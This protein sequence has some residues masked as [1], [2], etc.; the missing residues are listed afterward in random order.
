MEQMLVSVVAA[1]RFRYEHEEWWSGE[2]RP[3][4]PII[5]QHQD[6]DQDRRRDGSCVSQPS[7][8][9]KAIS[10]ALAAP[11]AVLAPSCP[12]RSSR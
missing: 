12:D 2:D 6:R 10:R 11:G 9:R 8:R 3:G 7:A 5:A 1:H 4:R